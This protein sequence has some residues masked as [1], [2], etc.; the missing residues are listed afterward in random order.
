MSSNKGVVFFNPGYPVGANFKGYE[1]F[2]GKINGY[3]Y[4]RMKTRNDV[5]SFWQEKAME[6]GYETCRNSL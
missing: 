2:G 6:I 5:I 3:E 1:D 4:I